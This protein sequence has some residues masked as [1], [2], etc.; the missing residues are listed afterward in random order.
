MLSLETKL[1]IISLVEEAITNGCRKKIACRDIGLSIRTIQRW[2]QRDVL[3]DQRPAALRIPGNKLTRNEEERMIAILNSEEFKDQTPWI[4]VP[5]L[6]DRN[7]Y[8]ASESSFY[9]LMRRKKLLGHRGK[10]KPK[11]HCKPDGH[12]TTYSNQVWSWDITYLR[13]N[14]NGIFFYLY[15]IMDIYSR[16]IVGWRIHETQRD[17]LSSA[18]IEEACYVEKIRPA[19]LLVLHSDNGSPMKGSTML[20]TLQKLGVVPSFSRPGVSDDNPYSES[21]FKTLKY[22]PYFPSKPF[23]SVEQASEWVSWFV[24]WYNNRRLH[25]EINYVTPASRHIGNDI[26]TLENR[27]RVYEQARTTHPERWSSSSRNWNHTREVFL[28]PTKKQ[29]SIKK[30]DMLNAA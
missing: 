25:G 27:K 1:Y 11:S 8:V 4:I 29:Q 16:K 21:L 18:L 26:V 24:D 7:E 3:E 12:V 13:S 22:T 5:S 20:C 14:V 30:K 2:E 9:R 19:A 23:E 10:A 17:E 28:N 6:A 15:M